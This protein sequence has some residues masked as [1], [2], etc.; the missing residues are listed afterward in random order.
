MAIAPA[1]SPP[2]IQGSYSYLF[3]SANAPMSNSLRSIHTSDYDNS[4][5]YIQTSR[6]VEEMSKPLTTRE[7]VELFLESVEAVRQGMQPALAG[8][9]NAVDALRPKLTLEMSRKGLAQIPSEVVSIIRHDVERCLETCAS[10]ENRI[11]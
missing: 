6:H 3:H 11:R 10:T 1:R 4:E 5:Y 8:S 2:T 7:S 9:G